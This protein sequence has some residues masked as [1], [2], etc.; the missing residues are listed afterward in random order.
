MYLTLINYLHTLI[1]ILLIVIK[2]WGLQP[3]KEVSTASMIR[4]CECLGP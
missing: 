1:I 3:Q 4:N 2:E